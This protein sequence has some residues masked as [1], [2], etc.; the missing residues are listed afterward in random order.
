[1][2]YI[3]IFNRLV[4]IPYVALLVRPMVH[5]AQ[6]KIEFSDKKYTFQLYNPK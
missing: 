4:G 5:D 2:V 1:M 3:V 6:R